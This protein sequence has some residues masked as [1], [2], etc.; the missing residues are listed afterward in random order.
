MR[1][2]QTARNV[3]ETFIILKWCY[4]NSSCFFSAHI[5]HKLFHFNSHVDINITLQ[6]QNLNTMGG[7]TLLSLENIYEPG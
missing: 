6:A 1:P 5:L 4:L 2:E 7:Q 3:Y